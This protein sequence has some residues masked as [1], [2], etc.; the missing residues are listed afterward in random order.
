MPCARAQTPTALVPAVGLPWASLGPCLSGWER[1]LPQGPYP[2]LYTEWAIHEARLAKARLSPGTPHPKRERSGGPGR[3]EGGI[4]GPERNCDGQGLVPLPGQE[5]TISAF[6]QLLFLPQGHCEITSFVQSKRVSLCE[7]PSCQ[8]QAG[9]APGPGDGARLRANPVPWGG[10][11]IGGV[12][13]PTPGCGGQGGPGR[14]CLCG[15]SGGDCGRQGRG[16]ATEN[17]LS[18]LPK[19]HCTQQGRRSGLDPGHAGTLP[20]PA[21]SRGLHLSPHTRSF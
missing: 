21:H 12:Q 19:H 7:V 14:L 3:E 20:R 17:T 15:R 9:R 11:S 18:L 4:L 5:G 16:R 2:K 13:G 6:H 8:C 1:L 10:A